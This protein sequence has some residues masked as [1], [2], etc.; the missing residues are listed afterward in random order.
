MNIRIINLSLLLLFSFTACN[1][2]PGLQIQQEQPEIPAAK[3]ETETKTINEELKHEDTV[4]ADVKVQYP[5]LKG[6][7]TKINEV[8][9]SG[10]L[11][12]LD[13]FKG[14]MEEIEYDVLVGPGMYENICETI[15]LDEKVFSVLC[16]IYTYTGGAHPNTYSGTFNFDMQ[17]EEELTIND[18]LIDGGIQR[19]SMLAIGQLQEKLQGIDPELSAWIEEGAAPDEENFRE[20][21]LGGEML[22]IYFDPYEVAPYA[23]GPQI[24]NI[25]YI[26]IED[27]LKIDLY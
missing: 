22:T 8:I 18:V 9:E 27:V 23:A 24:V 21:T 12:D 14:F 26:S 1:E 15:R 10:V 19:I 7:H 2:Q 11:A 25:L 13:S 6:D 4:Y 17:T 3:L 20:F 16:S 5:I